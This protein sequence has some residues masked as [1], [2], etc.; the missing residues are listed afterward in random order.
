MDVVFKFPMLLRGIFGC[1]VQLNGSLVIYACGLWFH[2]FLYVLI[3]L[4][5]KIIDV[6]LMGIKLWKKHHNEKSKKEGSSIFIFIFCLGYPF[7]EIVI[8]CCFW[9]GVL[10]I[11]RN[12]TYLI[13]LKYW[14]SVSY[15]R[16]G[17]RVPFYHWGG[18][19]IGIAFPSL[20]ILVIFL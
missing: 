9:M 7:K 20:I 6:P 8:L 4:L 2:Q 1:C 15:T 14:D 3:W 16:K 12:V 5:E 17:N 13:P 19:Q 10:W 11:Q 18:P